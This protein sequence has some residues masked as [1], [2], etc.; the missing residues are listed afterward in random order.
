M[1][2]RQLA[3]HVGA[4]RGRTRAN[5]AFPLR[6]FRQPSFETQQRCRGDR[7]ECAGNALAV[8][9]YSRVRGLGAAVRL[10]DD[11]MSSCVWCEASMYVVCGLQPSVGRGEDCGRRV[12]T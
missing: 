11:E 9:V 8:R 4:C 7:H 12:N 3:E 6:L 5:F 2:R 10:H 1:T